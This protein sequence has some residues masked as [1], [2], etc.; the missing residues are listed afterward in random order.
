[1]A[2]TRSFVR[3]QPGRVS[4][5]REYGRRPA[6]RIPRAG[7]PPVGPISPSSR[8]LKRR[9]SRERTSRP[10]TMPR[11]R[12]ISSVSPLGEVRC[13]Q[14]SR[15]AS[16]NG[17]TAICGRFTGASRGVGPPRDTR[18]PARAPRRWPPIASTRHAV[19]TRVPRAEASAAALRIAT[20]GIGID[21][22]LDD[23]AEPM[24][25]DLDAPPSTSGVRRARAPARRAV[26]IPPVTG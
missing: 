9:R 4:H 14:A 10:S 19:R 3:R 21:R 11:F 16:V 25:H 1:M 13:R 8:P 15:L 17:S 18:P 7:S 22:A 20:A 2:P 24:R 12:M 6:R 23:G 5:R 26:E